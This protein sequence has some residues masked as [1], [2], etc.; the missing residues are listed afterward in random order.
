MTLFLLF[1]VDDCHRIG[2][3]SVKEHDLLILI[4]SVSSVE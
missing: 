4:L 1:F 2:H 3:F